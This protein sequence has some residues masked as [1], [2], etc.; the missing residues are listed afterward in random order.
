MANEP[1]SPTGKTV[2]GGLQGATASFLRLSGAMTLYGVEQLQNAVSIRSAQDVSKTLDKFETTLDSLT[3]SLV[4]EC[5]P[6]KKEGVKSIGSVAQRAVQVSFEGLKLFN[7]RWAVTL[8]KDLAQ[9][10]SEVL[11]HWVGKSN[12]AKTDQPELAVEVL[13]S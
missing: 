12:S 7:P 5:D 13:G 2:M 9:K 4:E 6:G 10:S 8:T 3:D 11:S 1:T